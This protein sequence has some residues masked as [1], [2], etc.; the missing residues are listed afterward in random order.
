MREMILTVLKEEQTMKMVE[1]ATTIYLKQTH[2]EVPEVWWTSEKERAEIYQVEESL[3]PF[4]RQM[5]KEGLVE[6]DAKYIRLVPAD[7]E[8]SL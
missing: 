2:R 8:V 4:L 5:R 1:L 6:F 7:S 3:L